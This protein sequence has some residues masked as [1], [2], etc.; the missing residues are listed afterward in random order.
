MEPLEPSGSAP[1]ADS[2]DRFATNFATN[3][4]VVAPAAS[5]IWRSAA[6]ILGTRAIDLP[7]R[8]GF[9]LLVAWKL[10]LVP[11]GAFYIGFSF[12][13]LA[14]GLGRLGVDRA[15]T[16]EVARAMAEGRA[17][18]A[19]AVTVRGLLIIGGLSTASAALMAGLAPVFAAHLLGNAA[20]ARPIMLGAGTIV[21][22]C[23]SAGIAGALAGLGRISTSQM[24]YSW[25]WPGLFCLLAIG[26]PLTLDRAMI[27]IVVATTMTAMIA[28]AL[29]W[30]LFPAPSLATAKVATRRELMTLSLS[31]FTTEIIQLLMAALPALVLGATV[32]EAAV[33]AYALAWRVSLIFNLLVVAIAAMASPRYAAHWVHGDTPAIRRTA[34]DSVALV[35]GTGLVP[36]VVLAIGAPWILALFGHG[37]DSG[38]TTLRLLLLGQ[39]VL[40]ITATTP[41]LLGMTGHERAISRANTWSGV[42]FVPA[43]YGLSRWFGADGAALATVVVA[44][45]NASAAS[46]LARRWLGFSPAGAFLSRFAGR[47]KASRDR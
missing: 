46:L 32:D 8:Y 34:A 36:L 38:T 17:A 25:L 42:I 44:V 2:S 16:R 5:S 30:R 10:G 7:C 1:S 29:L 27:L 20:L 18:Q 28:A 43:L 19:R 45:V 3:A 14:A 24:I 13:T 6:S 15:L 23:L 12:L 22:L 37:F 31:L 33:G 35:L 40:M 41:E 4:S 11:A 47:R 9:H 26:I 39:F 21:P